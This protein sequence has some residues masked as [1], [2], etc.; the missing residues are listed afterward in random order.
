MALSPARHK[1]YPC[2]RNDH[3]GRRVG[4]RFFGL[5]GVRAIWFQRRSID[6]EEATAQNTQ[7]T[8]KDGW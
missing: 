1:L 8:W 2:W 6:F 3:F 4:F 7:Q 5:R